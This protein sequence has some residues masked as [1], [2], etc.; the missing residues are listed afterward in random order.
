MSVKNRTYYFFN[1]L[2][3]VEGSDSNL[4]KICEKSYK[5]IDIYY[6][7]YIAIKGTYYEH[8]NN[9]VNPLYIIIGKAYGYTEEKIGIILLLLQINTKKYL[10]SMQ[11]FGMKLN[12]RFKQ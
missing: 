10:K 12:I 7:G 4:V 2:I 9:S 1:H 11:N 5:N 8:I 3:N 6:I